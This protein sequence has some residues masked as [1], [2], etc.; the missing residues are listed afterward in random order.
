MPS[1]QVLTPL[2]MHR[3]RC[4]TGLFGAS[5]LLTALLIFMQLRGSGTSQHL[6]AQSGTDV[7]AAAFNDWAVGTSR[8]AAD[9]GCGGLSIRAMLSFRMPVSLM[10]RRPC[11]LMGLIGATGQPAVLLT[12]LRLRG[13]APRLGINVDL[14]LG[15]LLPVGL[16][17]LGSYCLD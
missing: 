17:F 6:Q 15:E 16:E 4:L 3:P 12:F 1:F 10:L 11:C 13:T 9:Y 5:G 2:A 7:G 8:L 14:Y